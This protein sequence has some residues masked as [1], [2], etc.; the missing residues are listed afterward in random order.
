MKRLAKLTM[1]VAVIAWLSIPVS[2]SASDF[3]RYPGASCQPFAGASASAFISFSAFIA[4]TTTSY[5]L[6]TCP[7][8]RDNDSFGRG[9]NV[10]ILVSVGTNNQPMTC[11]A[12][13]V[14]ASGT[15]VES[16]A[17]TTTT[18]SLLDFNIPADVGEFST[19]VY[20][21]VCGL[22]PQGRIFAYEVTEP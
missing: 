4:N 7:I 22:P 10:F 9:Q 11:I 5:Q 6:V 1:S 12:Y 21:V 14:S 18:G 20:S 8:V 19:S 17:N 16:R 15:I 13:N 3:K 2:V